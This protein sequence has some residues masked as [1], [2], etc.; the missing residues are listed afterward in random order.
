MFL[1]SLQAALLFMI[2]V[3]IWFPYFY[4]GYDE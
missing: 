1:E 4:D 3:G 2:A